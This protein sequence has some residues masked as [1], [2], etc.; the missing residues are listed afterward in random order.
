MAKFEIF[1]GKNDHYY[2]HLKANNGQII[3]QSQGYAS[4]EGARK[5]I[6]AIKRDAPAAPVEDLTP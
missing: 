3:A 4:K 6:D 2:F 5:G 1:L